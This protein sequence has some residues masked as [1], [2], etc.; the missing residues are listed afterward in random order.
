MLSQLQLCRLSGFCTG[1]SIPL[2]ILFRKERGHSN[3]PL[4][5]G[6]TLLFFIIFCIFC[7]LSFCNHSSICSIPLILFTVMHKMSSPHPCSLVLVW[8]CSPNYK[9]KNICSSLVVSSNADRL[10]YQK[11]VDNQTLHSYLIFEHLIQITQAI[12][13]CYNSL[14]SSGKP[15]HHTSVP[16]DFRVLL[17]LI[18]NM[19]V[20]ICKI[21][22]IHLV[23]KQIPFL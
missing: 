18:C 17:A 15:F 7:C 10:E 2:L 1:Y 16:K 11:Y 13:C 23:S 22:S 12:M 3:G 21:K 19:Q 20:M 5:S 6:F 8:V 9:K 4:P 14:H